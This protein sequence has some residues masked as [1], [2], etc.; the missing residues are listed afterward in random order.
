V[1]LARG[2]PGRVMQ[3]VQVGINL[4]MQ[5]AVAAALAQR[6]LVLLVLHLV[7]LEVL[8]LRG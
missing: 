3:V 7:L 1:L 4:T 5:A 8:A 2:L 6:A